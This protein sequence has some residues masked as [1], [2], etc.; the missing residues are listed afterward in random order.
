MWLVIVTHAEIHWMLFISTERLCG[1]WTACQLRHLKNIARRDKA[2]KPNI[3]AVCIGCE[4]GTHQRGTSEWL[5]S[6]SVLSLRWV[7]HMLLCS[8]CYYFYLSYTHISWTLLDF[9]M[10]L[11]SEKIENHRKIA[12]RCI[13]KTVILWGHNALSDC[14]SSAQSP[15]AVFLECYVHLQ[16]PSQGNRTKQDMKCGLCLKKVWVIV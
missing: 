15:S 13:I 7:R 2:E 11:M 6:S 10:H 14:S 4:V 5:Q 16:C 9:R 1:L 3:Q 8:I 12:F